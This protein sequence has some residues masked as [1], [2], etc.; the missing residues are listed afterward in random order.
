MSLSLPACVIR[1]GLW[2]I[3]DSLS[4]LEITVH[5]VIEKIVQVR[6]C[7][8][9]WEQSSDFHRTEANRWKEE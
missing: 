5:Y 4:L 2:G 3:V 8:S 6:A 7:V 9:V 1:K